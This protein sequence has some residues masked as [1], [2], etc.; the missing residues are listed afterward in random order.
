MMAG[1]GGD[2]PVTPPPPDRAAAPMEVFL[3]GRF[4]VARRGDLIPR[5]SWKRRRPADVLKLVAIAPGRALARE[6]VISTL[7]P[8][9]DPASGANNLHRALYD[10]R[11]VLGGRFVDLERGFVSLRPDVW[12]DVEA[13]EAAAR[14]GEPDEAREAIALYEGDLCPE[15]REAPWLAKRRE[16]LRARM[17]A[18]ALPLARAA[19]ERGDAEVAIPLLRRVLD[20]G[21]AAREPRKLLLRVL[22]E[23][24]QRDEALRQ[25]D[26]CEASLRDRGV[27]VDAELRALRDAVARGE[28]GPTGEGRDGYRHSARRLLGTTEPAPVRGRSSSLLLFESLIEQGAGTLVLLG[29]PGV[30]KTR[31]AVEGARIAQEAG[32]LV[33]TAT[34]EPL[35]AMP[36][37]PFADLVAECGS[38]GSRAVDPFAA[39]H[40]AGLP[41]EAEKKR[42]FDAV[43]AA[44][45]AV[46]GGRPIYVLLDDLHRID[47]S[48]ANLFH[49]LA[50]SAHALGLML[51]GTCREDAVHSGAPV[52]MLLAHLDCER[53]ARGIRVQRLDLDASRAQLADLL[54]EVPSEAL[55]AR[56]Y[57][58]T[59][60]NPFYTE[61]LARSFK[62]SGCVRIPDRP[63][64]AI[65]ERLSHLEPSAVALLEAAAVAGRFDLEIARRATGLGAR[66]VVGALELTLEARILDGD[67][68]GYHFHHSLTRAAV[69]ENLPAA[70]RSALHRAVA[71]AIEA[72][73]TAAQGG[74]EDVSE[75][76][77]HHRR[78]GDQPDRAFA[79]LVEAGR[80]AAARAGLREANAFFEG[81][82][83][84]GDG[85]GASGPRRLE[86]L[87]S[88]G[89]VR[90]ALADLAGAAR[91]FDVAA[92]L[93]DA[94]G[95][96]PSPEARA[97]TR[98]G[99]ALALLASGRA[100]EARARIEAAVADALCGA[101]RERARTS[102]LQAELA[103]HEGRLGDAVAAARR[104]EEEARGLGEL[105]LAARARD[106]W[107]SAATA[108][109]DPPP[110]SGLDPVEAEGAEEPFPVHLALWENELLGD[111]PLGEI[112]AQ[113]SA[114]RAQ[115]TA[116]RSVAGVA[117]AVTIGGAIA[118]RAGRLDAAEDALREAVRLQRELG[119][120]L[121]EAIATDAL[122]RL[123]TARGR[124][125]EAMALL[126]EGALVAERSR[127]RRHTLTRL[128]TA[129]AQ[130][131][132]AAGAI[133]A[134]EDAVR[135][136]SE[137]LARHGECLVCHALFRPVAIRV[138]L[139]R[140]RLREA[141]READDL[142][143]LAARRGGR[144]LAAVA[145]EARGRVLAGLG[146]AA[147]AATALVEAADAHDAR[148][149]LFDG[150]RAAALAARALR[151]GGTDHQERAEAL[152]RR[153][154]LVLSP[155]GCSA[156][157]CA[158]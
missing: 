85:V 108:L 68:S 39:H 78:A 52:Q 45:A 67:G 11:Q 42:L 61:E 138:A 3:L 50:R 94:S 113:V 81:A 65:A 53:L 118:A 88:L 128:Q 93:S 56:F 151:A 139:L 99:A 48:S 148:G 66:E 119:S 18:I 152:A 143:A 27:A 127:L 126:G 28:I 155:L 60:G 36:Y 86:L 156:D 95:W 158:P 21:S 98:S 62:E 117:V 154:S 41:P 133:Y 101:G 1:D 12:L 157:D 123:L 97:R 34:C 77:A 122:A 116:R 134:A 130:N 33:L 103:W 102:L 13:F 124:P 24:G 144:G 82:L 92:G 90:L 38:R 5:S 96:R 22:A 132:L 30:G 91:A 142:D 111:R 35:R 17:A 29:E 110:A 73:V 150:A 25:F 106:V 76:L 104:A 43:G 105:A 31:L 140:G 6:E 69:Y 125:E 16:A 32:A 83:A 20:A 80:R 89:E 19:A 107:A 72:R 71:D 79:H 146:R 63:A 153:A 112:E 10:L 51:V 136:A 44:L 4:E 137:I 40:P 70:R 109:G 55:A 2:T 26:T 131:R 87:E 9:R 129:L 121:G 100:A 15:D 46:G 149:A 115:V 8:D 120:A 23:T 14:S 75:E 49:F 57:R 147:D 145:R 37:A 58:V 84:L 7:W 47:E 141:E 74:V 64:S 114:Y 59:D 54:G 135:Q